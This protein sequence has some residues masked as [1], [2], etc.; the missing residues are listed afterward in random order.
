M[1]YYL[2]S[3]ILLG[4]AAGLSPG[5]LL[6]LVVSETLKHGMGAGIRVAFSPI[7][8]DAPIIIAALLLYAQLTD[9]HGLLGGIAIAGAVYVFY[10]GYESLKEQQAQDGE[11]VENPKSLLKGIITNALSPHPYLFWLMIGAPLLVRAG[12]ESPLYPVLF[13]STFY[14]LLVG[15]KLL[16]AIV[17][18]RSR[19]FLSS[20]GYSHVM[21]FLGLT[22]IAFAFLLFIDGLELLGVIQT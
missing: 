13:V 15:M 17:I 8:T 16:L 2:L 1:L 6:T 19:G 12:E 18:G 9:F 3:G 14:L 4:A 20:R 22:L 7:L 21:K 11:V 5:P 10:M